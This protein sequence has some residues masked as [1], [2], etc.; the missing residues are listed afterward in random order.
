MV[1]IMV[2][3][4]LMIVI[5]L[6]VLGFAQISRR[7]Q[8]EALDR[9]LST[10]AFYAAETGINDAHKLI[11]DAIAA[12]STITAKPNCDNT[13]AYS[14]LVDTL[15]AAANVKYTCLTVNPNPTSLVY[16][17]I[18]STSAIMPVKSAD[19]SN[20]NTIKLT[21]QA[22]TGTTP[23]NNCP[24]ST[25]NVFTKNNTNWQCGY[26]VLRFDLVPTAGAGLNADNLRKA[27]MTSFVVPQRT[28]GSILPINYQAG[29][30]NTNN[31]YGLRC[32][33]TNCTLTINT[34]GAN[35][36]YFYMR[37]SSL[38]KDVSLQI[39]ATN[40]AGG[41]VKLE[42]AQAVIDA[43]GKAQDVLRRIQV[44]L[45]LQS[46]SENSLPDYAIESTDAVCK[47]FAVMSGYFDNLT[48]GITSTN[49]LCQP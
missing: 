19:G 4:V 43:T 40:A 29:S 26:G 28:G 17:N 8:R 24:T 49:P 18:S 36:N 38:Y 22:K 48:A 12:G 13:G 20:L 44:R 14:T 32:D 15:D 5:S 10:Q 23:I 46:Q 27:T 9:Q 31:R 2:T 7:N 39:G 45:P 35:S 30:A 34:A 33:N 25:N 6:I 11:S 3:M 41:A 42:G 37:V 47:R 1:S 21:W 16:S